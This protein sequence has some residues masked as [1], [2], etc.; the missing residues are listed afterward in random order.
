MIKN[1]KW[2][3]SPINEND[4]CYNFYTE[5][6]TDK[7]VKK[8]V[9]KASAMGLY[10]AYVNKKRV[11]D[12]L[13]T[14]YWTEHKAH[15]QY[16]TYDVT[17]MLG[18][19]NELSFT[20]AEGW[21]VGLIR[22]GAEYRNHYHKNISLIFSL[23]VTYGDGS[24]CMITSDESVRVRTSQI[25]SSSIYDGEFVDKT[26]PI[27][28]LGFAEVD[29]EVKTKLEEQFGEK[30]REQ[31]VIYPVKMIVTPRGE[32]VIDFGQNFAG[33]VEVTAR[34][35][36]GSKIVLSHAEV[37]DGEGN[38]YTDNLRT[39]K[40][41]N[42]YVLSGEGDE[43]FK[44][45]F[46]WQGF[47]YVRI[48]E[49]PHDNIELS[50]FKG[51]V[52]HSD[53]KRTGYFECGNA[54]VNQLYHN[55]IWGQKSNFIDVPT[56]CPQRDERLGWTGDAQVF[57]R[58]AAINYDV[59]K[60]FAKWLKDLAAGQFDDGGVGW[61]VPSSNLNYPENVSS[62]WGDAAVICPWEIYLAYGN[63]EILENQFES[64]KKWIDYMHAFGDEEFLWIGGKQLGDWLAMDNLD[65]PVDPRKGL[66]STDFISSA[67]FAYSTSLFIKMGCIL[68]RDM[69]E[70]EM[71]YGNI[72]DA[73]GKRF[74]KDGV[75][76]QRTQ[77]ACV[78]A[79]RFDLAADKKKT[80]EVLCE[81]I[82][83]NGNKLNTGFLGTPH[84]LHALS[85]NG[86]T[87]VAYD[88]LLREE[89]P[90]WLYQV[91]N[92]ATTIW[93]HWDSIKDDGSFWDTSMNSFNHY[94]YGSVYDWMFGVS[95]GIKP[96]EDGAGYKHILVK[97][98]PDKRLGFVNAGIET[99]YGRLSSR[100]AYT[101]D[102]VKYEIRIPRGVTAEIEL[103]DG[104]SYTL[105][106]GKYTFSTEI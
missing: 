68:G 87:D 45:S 74:L 92:G 26:A 33:Y 7:T 86:R 35:K 52:I 37:L 76:I 67:F 65:D 30:V 77:T 38:F 103:P 61:E 93:E 85:E 78:L 73:F 43:S 106:G 95:A 15:T 72:V 63:K 22:T 42:T 28:E 105:H 46:T 82:E 31:D 12:E 57:V 8:A 60:F 79:L 27:K 66:T 64:M 10:T 6:N 99:R 41:K 29:T 13:L 18:K 5:F 69:T 47:R 59:E 44:P 81:L 24:V 40:Q 32:K 50:D 91:N 34:G 100:W 80:T 11:G 53:I 14:P 71:L 96:L 9:L 20:C 4:A 56:D 48:D 21:A 70:Y 98:N 54:K 3:M 102:C 51:I 23:E 75:P 2:I 39:A 55:V 1:A 84:I 97:P 104:K 88:L 90:S 89:S 58:T 36:R 94:A 19:K 17:D 25:V 49:Y 16:Q 62:G 101:N 83:K